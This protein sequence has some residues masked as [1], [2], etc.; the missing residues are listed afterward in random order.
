[1]PVNRR[2]SNDLNK[3]DDLARR[4][5]AAT[6]F[7]GPLRHHSAPHVR[8]GWESEHAHRLRL[9]AAIQQIG[10]LSGHATILD[11]GC[12]E[13]ALL[14]MLR[15]A[16]FEGHYRGEDV[17]S[18]MVDGARGRHA[19]D[20]D[21]E[22]VV[23]DSFDCAGPSAD[24]VICSGA[25]NT[26]IAGDA[27]DDVFEVALKALWSR[28]RQV[29]C[30]DVAIAD[31]HPPGAQL[32]A[33][34]PGAGFALA[35]GLCRSVIW[36]EDRI[37]GEVQ[38]V[39]WRDRAASLQAIASGTTPLERADLLLQARESEA[40]KRLLADDRSDE[41]RLLRAI[42]DAQLGRLRDAE[43]HLRTLV[44]GGHQ[45]ARAGLHL[46]ALLRGTRRGREAETLLASVAS[47]ESREADEARLMLVEM[48]ADREPQAAASWAA[49]ISDDFIAREARK[50]LDA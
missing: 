21:A 28:T 27:P 7:Y 8:V 24:V 38:I 34:D 49:A 46:A 40:V 25:L 2:E 45:R 18:W 11:G 12:G 41:A 32:A 9:A 37:F 35:R 16:G 19:S 50:H 20:P 44:S 29:L 17:L 6:A 5:E 23:F 39:M 33:V 48:M 42:A 4:Q 13:G 10:P 15:D 30:L 43:T 31:R 47:G 36:R 22:F 1:M 26:V 3:P 14:P